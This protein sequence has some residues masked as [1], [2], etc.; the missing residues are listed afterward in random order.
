VVHGVNLSKPF[1]HAILFS[2]PNSVIHDLPEFLDATFFNNKSSRNVFLQFPDIKEMAEV[3]NNLLPAQIALLQ[4]WMGKNR[5][6]FLNQALFGPNAS[7]T[8]TQNFKEFLA[9]FFWTEKGMQGLLKTMLARCLPNHQ[10]NILEAN[11]YINYVPD[12]NE[13]YLQI[14]QKS[15]INIVDTLDSEESSVAAHIAY[16]LPL[17]SLQEFMRLYEQCSKPIQMPL[18]WIV[19]FD[20][21][22]LQKPVTILSHFFGSNKPPKK[23]DLWM[24]SIE[25]LLEGL[26]RNK[27]KFFLCDYFENA[28]ELYE[29]CEKF[30]K[31][32]KDCN[33]NKVLQCYL[34]ANLQQEFTQ[35]KCKLV[36][37]I[38]SSLKDEDLGKYGQPTSGKEILLLR[39][40]LLRI[41]F[42]LTETASKL[43]IWQANTA[44]TC[45]AEKA[46]SHLL[47]SHSI[48]ALHQEQLERLFAA[49]NHL[50]K[51]N[52]LNHF[53]FTAMSE[54]YLKVNANWDAREE[55]LIATAQNALLQ[56]ELLHFPLSHET[57]KS[58][59][60]QAIQ[61]VVDLENKLAEKRE[62]LPEDRLFNTLI[63]FQTALLKL[64]TTKTNENEAIMG[65]CHAMSKLPA[66]FLDNFNAILSIQDPRYAIRTM[67]TS[68]PGKYIREYVNYHPERVQNPSS[69]SNATYTS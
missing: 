45:L 13:A 60:I 47:F 25:S 52:L 21:Q 30:K 69:R 33:A 27:N 64:H 49:C 51:K 10:L 68:D 59:L 19:G 54:V 11:T 20:T 36:E 14:I 24:P 18:S 3:Q 48:F 63:A 65:L 43:P 44:L 9:Q 31:N 32:Q 53:S 50:H 23:L 1:T 40:D 56:Q 67:S 58:E 42:G 55:F 17:Y 62:A 7:E 37:L 61:V 66:D 22:R 2:D 15:V 35:I 46:L 38:W 4:N 39:S 26:C 57:Q 41:F 6:I 28:S 29:M 8:Q 5:N 16:H 34:N 12:L